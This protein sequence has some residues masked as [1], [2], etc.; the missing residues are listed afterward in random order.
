MIQRN[1]KVLHAEDSNYWTS[2]SQTA[3]RATKFYLPHLKEK[4]FDKPK[5]QPWF[6]IKMFPILEVLN[7]RA[8]SGQCYLS[9]M[10]K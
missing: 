5:L 1:S 3:F 10:G 9:K 8:P 2:D 4:I 6:K 7:K